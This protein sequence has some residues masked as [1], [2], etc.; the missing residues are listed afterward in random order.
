MTVRVSYISEKPWMKR[1]KGPFILIVPVLL[2]IMIAPQ[3][4]GH[5]GK[6]KY[7]IIIDTDGAIDDLRAVTT[8]LACNDIRVLGIIG[9]QG[10]LP[11]KSAADKVNSLLAYFHHE[12]IPVGLGRSLDQAIP[13]W[14]AFASSVSWGNNEFI[15]PASYQEAVLLMTEITKSYPQKITLIALGA[16]TNLADWL[17]NNPKKTQMV[18]RIIWYN[19]IDFKNGFNYQTDPESYKFIHSLPIPL[20][21]VSNDRSNL[22]CDQA[23]IQKLDSAG[24]IYADHLVNIHK[25]IAESNPGK[26]IHLELGDDLV[27]LFMTCPIVFTSRD[28]Q[29]PAVFTLEKNIPASYVGDLISTVL[30]S[31]VKPNNRVFTDFPVNPDLY[32]KNVSD[33]LPRVIGDFGL[34][35]W[36]SVVLTNEI[37][38]HTGIYSIIG[39][40]MGVR[41]LEYFNV[42]VNN[43]E[44]VSYAGSEPPLSCL[45]DGI[46]IST[47]ATIGQGLIQ[48]DKTVIPIPTVIFVF[49]GKKIRIELK[50]EIA[51]RIEA[52]ISKGIQQFGMSDK[53]WAYVEELA[54]QYW[55]EL[56]R[57][58]IFNFSF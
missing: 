16:L 45:N 27:P 56:D 23:F 22:V 18:E 41:A 5:S 3:L 43:L 30:N 25:Q 13:F 47:G 9:S 57:H 49:N 44:V 6:P 42:G 39:V 20:Q 34:T 17:R 8:L 11:A 35:E 40:K 37:H 1:V 10:T 50:K 52:D 55:Q 54:Y 4:L 14:S 48:V 12:G 24:S 51:E 46:Q 19:D 33:F 38:G 7:H 29:H 21:V 2:S 53:Y 26:Q 32:K 31:S 15:E 28:G 36:K 58:V